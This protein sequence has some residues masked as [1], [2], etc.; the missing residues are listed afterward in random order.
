MKLEGKLRLIASRSDAGR[1]TGRLAPVGSP[2]V[3]GR[4]A[5]SDSA[6]AADLCGT[7]RACDAARRASHPTQ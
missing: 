5:I 3:G 2:P 1:A 4:R 7:R 6:R